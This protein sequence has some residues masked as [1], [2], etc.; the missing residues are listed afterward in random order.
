M[1]KSRHLS[2][3]QAILL[4]FAAMIAIGTSLLALPFAS[5]SGQSV[6]LLDAFF[7]ATS[8]SCVTGLVVVNTMQHWTWF[9]QLV[10]IT[11]IQLGGIGFITVVTGALIVFRQRIGLRQR[12]TIQTMF[13]QSSLGGMTRLVWQVLRY[14]AVIEGAGAV[15]L[16]VG[17]L[18]ANRGYGFLESVWYG[19]FHAISAFCNAG[20]DLVG[21]NSL[22]EFQGHW[23]INFTIMVLITLGG[24][25]FTVLHELRHFKT[26]KHW[27]GLSIHTRLVC[28]TSA[29][30]VVAGTL[31]F[32]LL[33]WQGALGHLATPQ[34]WLA[35]A[36]ES[37]TLRTAGFAT[38]DQSQL[39]PLSQLLATGFMFIGGSPAGTAGGVKTITLALLVAAVSSGLHGHTGI[40][41]AG[42]RLPLALVQK[43]LAVF[44]AMF[45]VVVMA[46]LILHFSEAGNS[47]APTL[48]ETI[49]EAT[50]ATGTVGLTTGL[51][52]YLSP[53]GKV[54]IALCMFIGRLSPLTLVVALSLRQN[55]DSHVIDYPAANVIIG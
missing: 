30:L 10:I 54:T 52:P 1:K 20:F 43:A 26:K 44:F 45:A 5:Q 12:L 19:V 23:L 48:M 35:A 11:L 51:T 21:S 2:A 25:G 16:T 3:P 55:A 29:V 42:R 8:A 27:R 24:L 49:F 41:I 39:T 15:L 14:T 18:T 34:K 46:V 32:A 50:S 13:N 28:G 7:T 22:A 37:V 38:I 31:L 33:E 9:G 47:F 6:S 40:V 53:I 4:S 36:F 17:F